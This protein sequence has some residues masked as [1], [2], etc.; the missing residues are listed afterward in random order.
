MAKQAEEVLGTKAKKKF[1][2][3]FEKAKERREASKHGKAISPML[4]ENASYK[5]TEEKIAEDPELA[6]FM[7]KV[8]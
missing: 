1:Q 8:S 2:T 4:K 6:K 3:P 5:T 7:D